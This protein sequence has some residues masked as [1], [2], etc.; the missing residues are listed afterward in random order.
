MLKRCLF[1]GAALL[2]AALTCRAQSPLSPIKQQFTAPPAGSYA[3]PPI[4]K[5]GNGW[6]FEKNWW[7][8]RLSHF[9]TGKIT[10]LSF[11][12]TYCS[13]PEGCPLTYAAML[14][15]K[16]RVVADAALRDRV[17]FVSLSFDPTNDT[18]QA[19][20]SYGGEHARDRSLPWHFLTTYSPDYLA[21]ILEQFG[22]DIEIEAD[23]TG[24]P[25]RAITHMVKVFLI[26]G[27]G[28]V[29]EIYS[30]A[31]LQPEVMYNDIKTLSFE[32]RGSRVAKRVTGSRTSSVAN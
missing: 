21:P 20:Q 6:V 7:P 16:R 28:L 13:D 29:R 19:M 9:M 15:V 25:T 8:R 18:P 31:F 11:V 30:T 4:Q 22:Q 32:V 17:R 12:Y 3:L 23:A 26:D 10:L 14:D 1:V 5:A 27:S 2:L 24:K